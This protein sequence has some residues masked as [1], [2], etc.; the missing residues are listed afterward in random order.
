MVRWVKMTDHFHLD[1][2]TTAARYFGGTI[3]DGFLLLSMLSAMLC[4]AVPMIEGGTISVD[5]GLNA[6]RAS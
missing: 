1:S 5:Y 2:E 6:A 4:S 3:A